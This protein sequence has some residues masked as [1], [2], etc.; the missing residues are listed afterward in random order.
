MAR[1]IKFNVGDTIRIRQWDDMVAE[2]GLDSDGDVRFVFFVRAMRHLCGRT[3]FITRIYPD[4]EVDL[5]G[6]SDQSGDLDW[7][8]NIN[9]MQ[10]VHTLTP[11]DVCVHG[12]IISN[13]LITEQIIQL[14]KD[15]HYYEE[16]NTELISINGY[17]VP[18]ECV[19]IQEN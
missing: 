19:T 4:G 6:W 18:R 17:Y 7:S 3:A 16:V 1:D 12:S 11:T 10:H 8:I 14:I 2:F 13:I 15:N 5:S 9:C